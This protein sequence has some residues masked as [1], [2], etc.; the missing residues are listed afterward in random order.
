MIRRLGMESRKK[1]E[2][3]LDAHVYLDLWVK[4]LPKWRKRAEELRRFGFPVP[5]QDSGRK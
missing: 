2:R 1:I 3:L 4:V 5:D